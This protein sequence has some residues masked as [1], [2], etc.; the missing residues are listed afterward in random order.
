MTSHIPFSFYFVSTKSPAQ[1]LRFTLQPGS[2]GRQQCQSN[3]C[4]SGL[5]NAIYQVD[6]SREEMPL[7][8][9]VLE[10]T[11]IQESANYTCVAM[12]S[13]G[14]IEATVQVTVK[15]ER[16]FQISGSVDLRFHKSV[17]SDVDLPTNVVVDETAQIRYRYWSRS[18][19]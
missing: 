11:N 14:M 5:T 4:S 1:I 15:G 7:G 18:G 3:M 19:F 10:L 9:S 8:R 2:D 13:L 12:S 6:L 17:N 16:W